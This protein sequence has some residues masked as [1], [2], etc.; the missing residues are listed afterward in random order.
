[1]VSHHHQ[2]QHPNLPALI[3][4]GSNPTMS[5]FSGNINIIPETDA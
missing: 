2:Y 3:S 1:M 5:L 4:P